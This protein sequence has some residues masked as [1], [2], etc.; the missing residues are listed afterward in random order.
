[1][2][3]ALKSKALVGAL[4]A[5]LVAFGLWQY[6]RLQTQLV[7]AQAGIVIR[8]AAHRQTIETLEREREH[9]KRAEQVAADRRR[10]QERQS[11]ELADLQREL[12][13]IGAT[14]DESY[15]RCRPVSV[16][17]PIRERLRE[18]ADGVAGSR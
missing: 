11:R 2:L 17:D 6:Q 13:E 10:E 7:E 15:R 1:M 12:T 9:R 8:D 4:G 18:H 14:A 5:A 16:P 3:A